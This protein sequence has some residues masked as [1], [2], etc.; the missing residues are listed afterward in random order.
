MYE[1][2]EATFRSIDDLIFV[3]D[4]QGV[5]RY[6]FQPT[7]SNLYLEENQFIG[8]SY[9]DVLPG[10]IPTQLE[11]AMQ[12]ALRTGVGQTFEYTL[13]VRGTVLWFNAKV[14]MRKAPDGRPDGYTLLIR[15]ITA[16]KEA[17]F[18]V[19]I[20]NKL[21]LDLSRAETL[22]EVA[23]LCLES[24]CK[25]PGID[26]GILY[27]YDKVDKSLLLID[28]QGLS[29]DTA[30]AIRYFDS[31]SSLS[32]LVRKGLPFYT[33]EHGRSQV[34][35]IVVKED[36]QSSGLI[37]II[38]NNQLIA[39]LYVISR[40]NT[41]MPVNT[42]RALEKV[43][44]YIGYSIAHARQ[45]EAI[46]NSQQDLQSLFDTILD[47]LIIFDKEGN[48]L[49]VNQVVSDRLGFN[50]EE[51]VGKSIHC[52]LDTADVQKLKDRLTAMEEVKSEIVIT[53]PLKTRNGNLIPVETIVHKRTWM[54]KV[55]MIGISRDI[56]DRLA[57]EE[58][59]KDQSVQMERGLMQQ[60]ILSEIALELNS[61]ED[62]NVRI[63][64]TLRKI[65]VHTNTS[66]VYIFEDN[67]DG[68]STNNT[69][70]WCNNG[71]LPQIEFLQ[72]VP[73]EAMPSLKPILD[74]EGRLYSENIV[75]LP[76]DIYEVL[77]PQ[78]IKAIIF[79]T[80][81]VKGKYFGFIGFDDCTGTRKWSLSELE[82][83]RTVSGIIAN[84]YE[85]KA[86]E[87]FVLD[88]RD[89]AQ[90]ANMAKTEFLANMSHEIRTPLNAVLGFSEALYT[91]L[92]DEDNRKMVKSVISSAN[93]LLSL[94]NDILDLSK[95]EA[96]KMEIVY[97]M[98]DFSSLIDEIELMFMD[99]AS[100]KGLSLTTAKSPD[101]PT[102]LNL[103]EIR[104]KQV[105]FNLVGNAVKFTNEGFIK[106]TADWLPSG[107]NSGTLTIRVMDSG[108]GIP[109]GQHDVIFNAFSQYYSGKMR[110]PGG[111]GLGL[112]ISKR[113]VEKMKG[114]IDVESI[115]GKGSTFTVTIP[116]VKTLG[117]LKLPAPVTEDAN[118]LI[119]E[120]STLM[121]VDDVVSNIE[122]VENHM[123]TIGVSVI[124]AESAHEAMEL[125]KHNLPDAMLV[126]IRM[127]VTGGVE[128]ARILKKNKAYSHIP[129]VAFTAHILEHEA[130]KELFEHILYKPV[131]RA[132]LIGLVTLILKNSK[133]TEIKQNRQDQT[134]LVLA[135]QDKALK[136][137]VDFCCTQE[138]SGLITAGS[139][140]ELNKYLESN[141]ADR[142][143]IDLD[144]LSPDAEGDFEWLSKG[145]AGR[146][147]IALTRS[148]D[149]PRL[150]TGL[151]NI[152]MIKP[153]SILDIH[154][155][156]SVSVSELKESGP[157]GIPV[158]RTLLP[159]RIREEREKLILLFEKELPKVE[160]LGQ[161][162]ST[163]R[164]GSLCLEMRELGK[165]YE[166]EYL[167]KYADALSAASRTYQVDQTG[168]LLEILPEMLKGLIARLRIVQ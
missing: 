20:E 135:L 99:K 16:A 6:V 46:R 34:S 147:V 152:C 104:I 125:L 118:H 102:S 64:N 67:P 68:T 66:R 55:A 130:E 73:Y 151:F 117:N 3:I 18:L 7:H 21:I 52:L 85:R 11:T 15:E 141:A 150:A 17:E 132:D 137:M 81:V 63:N 105:I 101:F 91:K 92:D 35:T 149:D 69:F 158:F 5:F 26:A 155:L 95:I 41:S 161:F 53:F 120:H 74:C 14:F 123:A 146:Q 89:K 39:S 122:V 142:L 47:F 38:H 167:V 159:V 25:M 113:L 166:L 22:R 10:F 24:T 100:S 13:P 107:S 9:K 42:R 103:D 27:V 148:L 19:E 70:E 98:T 82:L 44:T 119:F 60:T 45:E 154:Q 58:K 106:V 87:Q 62:F 114:T 93:L 133:N 40:T 50:R 49:H 43:S 121:V 136:R 75:D 79:Y 12:Q 162:R 86:M 144:L 111:T 84:A 31:T 32:I 30:K 143:L 128:L 88:E 4:L 90:Q 1:F 108:I 51:L 153:L 109:P 28:L 126:D 138:K 115:E 61:I 112:S 54:G 134:K 156:W 2:L 33:N 71:I 83:L 65:G 157:S 72:D 140:A 77:E 80:L 36:F 57:N 145:G 168:Y 116:D 48:I 129:L 131:R 160:S 163:Q 78:D 76:K 97:R 164:I 56:S 165:E 23:R 29:A 127:P 8:K 110:H 96:D 59:L 124:G 37:P 94:L 139:I